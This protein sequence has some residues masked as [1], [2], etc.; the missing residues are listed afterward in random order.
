[1]KNWRPLTIARLYSATWAKRLLGAIRTNPRQRGF[2][3]APGCRENLYLLT[4][5]MRQ[6]KKEGRPITIAFVDLAKAFNTVG[7]QHLMKSLQ[8]VKV[9]RACRDLIADQ[10]ADASAKFQVNK[11]LTS[12]IPIRRGVKQGD[13]LSPVLFNIAMD[14]MLDRLCSYDWGF[15]ITSHKKLCAMSFAD[16][17]ALAADFPPRTAT[18]DGGGSIILYIARDEA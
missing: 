17:L 11:K 2:I 14:A 6:A 8:R 18:D 15:S 1:M 5:A 10:Y 7:H 3:Q 16:D 9:D 4:G 13:P 12:S